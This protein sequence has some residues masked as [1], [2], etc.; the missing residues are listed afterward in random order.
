MPVNI[1]SNLVGDGLESEEIKLYNLINQYRAQNG[2]PPI[3]ASKALTTVANRH[4]QDVAENLQI[5]INDS[6]NPHS[7]SDAPY[8][9]NNPN[10]YSTVWEAPKRLNTGYPG[11]GYENFYITTAPF[12]SAEQVFE[13]WQKSP[14]HKALMLNQDIWQERTWN[15]L[16]IGIY[17][18]YAALWVG[19]QID[20]TGTPSFA[21]DSITG[22]DN[23]DTLTGTDRNDTI[24]ALAGDDVLF[25][26][27]GDDA[28]FGN[29]GN[30]TIFGWEGND[31]LQGGKDNDWLFGNLGKDIIYGNQGNDT[32]FGGKDDDIIYGGKDNDALFG[33]IGNDLISGDFG[34]DVLT[35]GAGNDLFILQS[36]K[37]ADVITDFADGVDLIGLSNGL[38]FASLT[39]TQGTGNDVGNTLISSKNQLL[40]VLT[41]VQA[42][43]ITDAD[44]R[45]I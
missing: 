37:G 28:L 15:A 23:S 44:F 27:S 17:K 13:A 3:A 1:Y 6:R 29:L 30:D 39:I 43:A 16:G 38:N 7:W 24:I 33:D 8:D 10:T 41:G 9:P 31:T 25:G 45:Q 14:P 36:A 19:E 35:G 12:T 34:A 11:F 18:G 26:Y 22:T 40:A 20:P 42:T 32:I 21:N 2:L 5:K 4:V